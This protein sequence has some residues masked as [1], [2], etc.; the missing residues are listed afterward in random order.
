METFLRNFSIRYPYSATVSYTIKFRKSIRN[1]NNFPPP[2]EPGNG[3]V[4]KDAEASSVTADAVPLSPKGKAFRNHPKGAGEGVLNFPR[5]TNAFPR[6][7]RF[8]FT[9]ILQTALSVK[10]PRKKR[11]EIIENIHLHFYPIVLIFIWWGMAL[12]IGNVFLPL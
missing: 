11:Y 12:Q 2:F 5:K 9:W 8:Y 4:Y 1:L 10:N 3:I 7:K 6:W